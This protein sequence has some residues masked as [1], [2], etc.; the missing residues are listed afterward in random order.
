MNMYKT[1]GAYEYW[2]SVRVRALHADV[3][4]VGDL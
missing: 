2:R 4:V 3:E 1:S